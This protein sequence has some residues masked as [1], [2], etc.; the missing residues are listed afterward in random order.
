M[1]TLVRL[2]R[3]WIAALALAVGFLVTRP[4]RAFDVPR[5]EGPVTDVAQVLSWQERVAI[6]Q[7]LDD[8]RRST[9]HEVAVVTLKSLDG[10]SIEEVGYRIANGWRVGTASR[11]DG[12]LLVVAVAERKIRVEVG[13]G[14]GHVLP[15]VLAGRIVRERIVPSLTRGAYGQGIENGVDGILGAL[16]GLEPASLPPQPTDAKSQGARLRA[17]VRTWCA[18]VLLP[19]GLVLLVLHVRGVLS[20]APA[21]SR[22]SSW[23]RVD[24][25]ASWSGGTPVDVGGPAP[26]DGHSSSS[27]YEGGGRFG[28]GGASG[29]Y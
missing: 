27:S 8:F 19:V 14:A 16:S 29:D 7:K 25:R 23:T 20:R 9:G 28:G 13:K 4:A 26:P 24:T 15:D 1:P 6:T 10:A 18:F 12:A 3:V 5:R 2:V 21:W 22:R 17:E 11:D